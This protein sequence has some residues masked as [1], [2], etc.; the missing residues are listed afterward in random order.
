MA[1][2]VRESPV[3]PAHQ[4]APQP[5]HLALRIMLIALATFV[6]LTAILGA[7]FALPTMPVEWLKKGLI[8]PFIDYTIPALALGVVCGGSALAAIFALVFRPNIGG[9]IAL[10]A[11]IMMVGF[12]LV[13]IFVVGF[14][15]LLYPT[16]PQGWLQVV[17]LLVGALMALFGWRLWRMTSKPASTQ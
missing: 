15:P 4:A 12:E 13:E 16:Q 11:G 10:I 14:T 5:T 3:A 1:P 8:T 7:M 6:A 17:Y 2:N 9:V